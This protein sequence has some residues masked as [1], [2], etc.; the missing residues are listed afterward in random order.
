MPTYTNTY[1]DLDLDFTAN[2]ITGDLVTVAD[3]V[4][5]KRV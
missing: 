5:V 4:S 3:A 1:K 2:P